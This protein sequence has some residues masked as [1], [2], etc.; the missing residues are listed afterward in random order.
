MRYF[1][2]TQSYPRAIILSSSLGR[3]SEDDKGKGGGAASGSDPGAQHIVFV[4]KDWTADPWNVQSD[5]SP[6]SVGFPA[7][8]ASVSQE[9]APFEESDRS[10]GNGSW[11][12]IFYGDVGGANR[13]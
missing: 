4:H 12:F 9:A 8:G 10:A 11:V 1:R 6:I 5:G 7:A 2:F 13:A 3:R